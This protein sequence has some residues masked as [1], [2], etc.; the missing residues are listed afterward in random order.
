M[1][2]FRQNTIRG[3]WALTGR[4]IKKWLKDPLILLVTIVQPLIWMALLGKSMNIGALLSN[5]PPEIR[6][7]MMRS[8]FGTSD[9]FSYMAVGMISF[10]VIFTAMFTG[11]S[12]VW[13]RR[14][15]FLDK[16]LSTPVPRSAII[17][18]KVLN[19]TIRSIFQATLILLAALALG[20][21]LGPTFTPLN[22]FGIYAVIFLFST[23]LS[24]LFLSFTLRSTKIETPMAVVN[25]IN[26]PLV[27]T[28]NIFFPN[29]LM[30]SWLQTVA[31]IN[32]V[33]YLTDA[34]RQLTIFEMDTGAL[35]LDL[36]YLGIL[37]V[38]LSAVGIFLAR[39]YLSR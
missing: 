10:T 18:A 29:S 12:V 23:G 27:F 33:S 7:Q 31:K 26:L 21:K 2:E 17:F 5:L 16:V 20:L 30:P 14:L 19:S 39:R 6:D 32:P 37:A 1:M 22:I 24:F 35:L 3:L 13:D 38:L 34:I 8:A 9:Y 4:E 25:L 36:T 15:G 11:M 28:S